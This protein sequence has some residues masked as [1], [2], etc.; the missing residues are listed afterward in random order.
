LV[1][2]NCRELFAQ[3]EFRVRSASIELVGFNWH[4][5]ATTEENGFL[6]L[7]LHAKQLNG[8]NG[9]YRIEVDWLVIKI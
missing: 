1:I 4:L 8:F 7:Y 3:D 9:N 5:E 2:K 6:G